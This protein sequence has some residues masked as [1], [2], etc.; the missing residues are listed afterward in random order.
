MGTYTGAIMH[1][2]LQLLVPLILLLNWTV[3]FAD[4]PL[5]FGVL[6]QRSALLTAQY[7]NPIL[8][9][10]SE[11]SGVPLRLKMGHT[12]PE[13]TAMTVR[14]EFA[15]AYTNHLFTPK[16]DRLGWRVIARPAGKGIQSAIVVGEASPVKTLKDLVGQKVGFPSKEAFAGYH[17]PMDALLRT[18][19]NVKPVFSCN[20]EGVMAQLKVGVVVAAAVN[21]EVMAAYAK[22]ENFH[23]RV[24]WRS[25][26][27]PDLAVMAHPRVPHS[28]VIAVKEAL[29]KMAQN[30]NGRKILSNGAKLLKLEG[31]IGFVAAD[32]R[33]YDIYR[34]FYRRTLLPLENE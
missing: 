14:G 8:T 22:R 13:T 2:I 23:Y 31:E 33:D 34:K 18:G 3:A 25:K 30:D 32:D 15:F 9:Y 26:V 28:K 16:R 7:W 19:I 20:Q 12:A 10:V 5:A 1:V 29:L 6:N 11:Q 4:E 21:S 27:Y 17:I 24:I